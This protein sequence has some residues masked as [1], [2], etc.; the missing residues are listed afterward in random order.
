MSKSYRVAIVGA[1][2]AVGAEMLRVM[3]RRNFPV[4]SLRLLASPRSSESS[5]WLRSM[6]GALETPTV[7]G[8]AGRELHFYFY[9][10]S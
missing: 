1:S 2:G 5:A 7:C 9:N 3:E 8:G 10:I 6:A 4:S